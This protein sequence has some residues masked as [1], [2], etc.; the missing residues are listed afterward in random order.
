MDTKR[1]SR[2]STIQS[3]NHPESWVVPEVQSGH[4]Q[5]SS[6]LRLLCH[7]RGLV[8]VGRKRLLDEDVRAASEKV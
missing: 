3:L 5:A 6:L 2:P 8:R 7:E 1:P 4:E